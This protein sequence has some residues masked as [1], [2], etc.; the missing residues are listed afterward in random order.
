MVVS[1]SPVELREQII[2]AGQTNL[3]PDFVQVYVTGRVRDPGTKTLPQG[4]SLDQALAAAGGQ[5]L[6][7]G[8]VEFI[9]FNR[10]GT[11]DKRKFFVGG[12]NPTGSYK[13]PILMAGDVVRVNDSP[14]SATVTVLNEITGPVVGIYSVYG[15][16]RDF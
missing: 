11:A 2:K 1:R 10:D 3:S 7:R 6:M 8:Q 15:L 14:V 13:N 9:R 16:F 5:K 4:A 12:A